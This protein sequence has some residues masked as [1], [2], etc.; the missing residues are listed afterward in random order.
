VLSIACGLG[1]PLTIC[2]F[3]VCVGVLLLCHCPRWAMLASTLLLFVPALS[4]LAWQL[5]W[6]K[7]PIITAQSGPRFEGAWVP[8]QEMMRAFPEYTLDSVSG[9]LDT[10]VFWVLLAAAA[11]LLI[12]G[13]VTGLFARRTARRS[14]LLGRLRSSR[15]L[16]LAAAMMACYLIVPLHLARPFDWWLVSGRF[17]PLICFF[18]FLVPKAP[19]RGALRLAMGPA[20]AAALFLP[21]HLSEKYVEVNERWKPLARMVERVPPGA[22]VIFLTLPPRIEEELIVDAPNQL[23]SWVQIM[24]GGFSA[25]GW[26]NVGFPFLLTRRLPAPPWNRNEAFDP[27][28][29]GVAYDYVIIRNERQNKPIFTAAH[30]AWRRIDEEGNFTMYARTGPR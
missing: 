16:A 14:T 12:W 11:F 7:S 27:N 10:T 18:G 20:V 19:I 2:A 23:S 9:D 4:L 21:L 5:L 25:N 30:T 28:V 8:W 26:Y 15:C 29:H 22:D 6:F 17:A 1:H 24:H 13:V 3:Y